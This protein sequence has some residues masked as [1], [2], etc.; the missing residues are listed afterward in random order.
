MKKMKKMKSTTTSNAVSLSALSSYTSE[1][2]KSIIYLCSAFRR[3]DDFYSTI[4]KCLQSSNPILFDIS[5]HGRRDKIRTALHVLRKYEIFKTGEAFKAKIMICCILYN[6]DTF[7]TYEL[8]ALE[9]LADCYDERFNWWAKPI[10]L[11]KDELHLIVA[12]GGLKTTDIDTNIKRNTRNT[13]SRFRGFHGHH[14]ERLSNDL[15]SVICVDL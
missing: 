14:H 7:I 12:L 8:K 3:N 6:K 5:V 9:E 1:D 10:D 13:N 11:P 15:I 2:L 4:E